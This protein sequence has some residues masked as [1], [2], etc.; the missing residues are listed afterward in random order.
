MSM[1]NRRTY[2]G[3]AHGQESLSS[4]G[5]AQALNGGTSQ[6]VPNNATVTIRADPGLTGDIYIGDDTVS[7]SNGFTLGGGDVIKLNVDDVSKIHFDGDSNG[8]NVSW[9]VEVES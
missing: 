5:T 1:A 6:E 4:S 9:I 7:S 2:G 8:Q 3:I